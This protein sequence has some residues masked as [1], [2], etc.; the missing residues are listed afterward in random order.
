MTGWGT[1]G[2]ITGA[3]KVIKAARPDIQIVCAEPEVAAL[4]SGAQWNPH[5]IQGWTPN[6]VP[7]ILDKN[8]FD[9]TVLVANAD[10]IETSR[11]LSKLEGIFCGISSGATVA[12]ALA[13]AKDAPEG[14]VILAMLPDT[15]ERYLSTGL[16]E[17]HIEGS[18]EI[19]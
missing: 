12:A 19:E 6:F 3:G 11:K 18:D 8:I 2:T 17:G 15:A 16:F 7:S 14:S 13:V 1:G 4:T 9:R 10:A 5:P